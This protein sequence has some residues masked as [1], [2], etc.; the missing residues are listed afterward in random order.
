[1]EGGGQMEAK[2]NGTDCPLGGEG[3]GREWGGETGREEL[4]DPSSPLPDQLLL[5]DWSLSLFPA[6]PS[7]CPLSHFAVWN[8]RKNW[9]AASAAGDTCDRNWKKASGAVSETVTTCL[10]IEQKQW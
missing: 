2:R 9:R 8:R 4:V 6:G 1:M 7:L 10:E 5:Q 3:V